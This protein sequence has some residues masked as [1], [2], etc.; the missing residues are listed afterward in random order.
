MCMKKQ[1]TSLF[2]SKTIIGFDTNKEIPCF[3]IHVPQTITYSNFAIL[4]GWGSFTTATV[5]KLYY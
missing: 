5:L 1:G 2:V 4:N 3:F